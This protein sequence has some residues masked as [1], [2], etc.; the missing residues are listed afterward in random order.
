MEKPLSNLEKLEGS[1]FLKPQ[2]KTTTNRVMLLRVYQ[3]DGIIKTM[4]TPKGKYLISLVIILVLANYLIIGFLVSLIAQ[5]AKPLPT[6]TRTPKPTYTP[7]ATLLIAATARPILRPATA[8]PTSV[9][10]IAETTPS[11]KMTPVA[12]TPTLPTPAQTVSTPTPIY[13]SVLTHTVQPG[14]GL[15]AIAVRYGVSAE[16]IALANQIASPDLIYVGQTLIIP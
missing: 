14:E 6:P 10:P 11:S 15:L 12:S 7:G 13:T 3:G 16:D 9:L 2:S 1:S 5:P 8:T 4:K